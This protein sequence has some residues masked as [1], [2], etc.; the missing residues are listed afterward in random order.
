MKMNKE[1][2]D[3]QIHREAKYVLLSGISIFLFNIITSISLNKVDM[4]LLHLPLWFWVSIVGSGIIA[5]VEILLLVKFVFKNFS[6]D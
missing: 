2:R 4:R 6:L 5:I 3:R 1:E